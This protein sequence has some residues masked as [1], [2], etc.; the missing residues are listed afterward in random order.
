MNLKKKNAL[1]RGNLSIVKR[2]EKT[3]GNKFRLQKEAFN[4]FIHTK[5]FEQ[6]FFQLFYTHTLQS[7]QKDGVCGGG[8]GGGTR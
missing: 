4:K 5:V 8:E 3:H 6:S 1:K 7:Q 2:K